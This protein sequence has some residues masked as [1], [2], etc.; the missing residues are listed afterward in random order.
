MSENNGKKNVFKAALEKVKD[1]FKSIADCFT[2]V[3]ENV[4]NMERKNKIILAVI[5]IV[6]LVLLVVL[7]TVLFVLI[8]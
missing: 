2:R 5:S 4:K 1:F 8:S 3:I 6:V 7:I